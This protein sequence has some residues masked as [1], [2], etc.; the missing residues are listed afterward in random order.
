MGK[1]SI[2]VVDDEKL[3]LDAMVEMLSYDG[4]KVTGVSSGREA[5]QEL[6]KNDF[7][8]LLT[9]VM[10]PEMNGIE[11]IVKVREKWPELETVVISGHGTE[12]TRNKLEMLGVFGYLDKPVKLADIIMVA[13]EG[14]RS[15]RLERLGC[16]KAGS[17]NVK[18]SRERILVADDD[19]VICDI[20]YQGLSKNGYNVST[21]NDGEKVLEMLLVNDY[22]MV[23]LDVKMPNMS[24]IEAVKAIRDFDPY[25]FVLLISGES[26]EEEVAIALKSGADAFLA[27]PFSIPGILGVIRKVNVE[28]IRKQK[29]GKIDKEK[30]DAGREYG[31]FRR[32]LSR[33]VWKKLMKFSIFE[34]LA[35]ILISLLV[36]ALSVY[37]SGGFERRN[38]SSDTMDKADMIQKYQQYKQY[39]NNGDRKA[40]QKEYNN[41]GK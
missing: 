5:L 14:I 34:F 9:D 13:R 24:G 8:L 40:L 4:F 33:H 41:S 21:V 17:P 38:S 10:M 18:L 20:L 39:M 19:T 29:L 6:A 36:G 25:T 35:I 37:L 16:G 28:K 27:K 12:A 22:D 7:G 1:N 15:N 30:L 32:F 11:L 3:M 26:V 31:L 2:L 23:V